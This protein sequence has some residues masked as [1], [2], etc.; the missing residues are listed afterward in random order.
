MPYEY[1]KEYVT[2]LLIGLGV[3][4]VLAVAGMITSAVI[5]RVG[6]KFEAD[7]RELFNLF[8]KTV[9]IGFFGVGITSFLGTVGIDVSAVIAGMGLTGFALGFAIKDAISNLL[10]GILIIFYQTFKVG[11]RITV[12]GCDGVV[13]EIN[14]RHT[15]IENGGDE[16]IIPNSIIFNNWVKKCRS[17]TP[18]SPAK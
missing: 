18:P 1:S 11:D 5:K 9:N 17:S 4:L 6:V 13:V 3:F 2:K 14:L 7:K 16:Y 10:S 12:V 8:G 15:K